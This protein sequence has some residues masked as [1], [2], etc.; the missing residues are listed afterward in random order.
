M[1]G[2]AQFAEPDFHVKRP[3]QRALMLAC[4]CSAH[5]SAM[6]HCS[7]TWHAPVVH[8]QVHAGC[9]GLAEALLM[10]MRLQA[11]LAA[12]V[13]PHLAAVATL[14]QK[15]PVP[16][17]VESQHQSNRRCHQTLWH[18][19]QHF[20]QRQ[21]RRRHRQRR[22]VQAARIKHP[23]AAV[24]LMRVWRAQIAMSTSVSIVLCIVEAV[25][26]KIDAGS[27]LQAC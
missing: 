18:Q 13:A 15:R 4:P 6:A 12:Q 2:R 5:E 14:H 25:I 26:C 16:L 7:S 9:L 27:K 24:R 3:W 20:R 11:S 19:A 10:H 21:L 17:A 23:S 8:G 1:P 22:Q